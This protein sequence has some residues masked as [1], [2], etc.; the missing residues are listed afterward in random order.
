MP[1]FSIIIPVFN[2]EQFIDKTLKSVLAQTYSDYEIILVNDGSTDESETIIKTFS[3]PR[4]RYFYKKNEG[5]AVARNFGI[6]KAQGEYLCFLDADDI[7]YPNFLKTMRVYTQKLPG[8]GVFA[9]AIEV[10]T[11]RNSFVPNYSISKKGDFDIVNFFEASQR[12]CVLWT[13]AVAI[14]KSVFT[15]VGQFDEK[16]KKSED[17]EL[18]IRIGLKYS[19]V[20]IWETLARYVYDENSISRSLNYF[21]EPYTFEKYAVLEQKNQ[22]LKQYMDLNRFSAVVKC[23]LSGDLETAKLLYKQINLENISSKKTILMELPD[24]V[25]RF[26]IR[27][28]NF[29]ADNGLG[30]SVF[31]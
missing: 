27:I 3:D 17:T 30:N 1:F 7:W 22:Q 25:L 5:V 18:W 31:R 23:K 10:E 8:Q 20:F 19:I 13:S 2:K 6:D 9:C 26:L 4:I 14:H 11:K 16:I 29:A 24:F 21:F 15:A 28:K 12:A